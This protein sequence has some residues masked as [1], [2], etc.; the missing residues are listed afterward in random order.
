[1]NITNG[2]TS[3]VPHRLEIAD[4]PELNNFS[5]NVLFGSRTVRNGVRIM[6]MALYEPDFATF[7]QNG[8]ESSM[9]YRNAYGGDC[10]LRVIYNDEK[11]NWTGE[12]F[13]NGKSA[14]ISF[15]AKWDMFFVH[16]TMPGLAN[17]ERCMFEKIPSKISE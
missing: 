2:F 17:G 3:F 9:E 5:L 4:R 12:K 15:G 10:W 13:V 16:F 14:W 7:R 11:K 1:M 6:G 8:A